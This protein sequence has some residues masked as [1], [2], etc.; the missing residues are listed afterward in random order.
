MRVIK[1]IKCLWIADLAQVLLL[2]LMLLLLVPVLV[3]L[4]MMVLMV[5]KHSPLRIARPAQILRRV[6]AERQNRRQNIKWSVVVLPPQRGRMTSSRQSRRFAQNPAASS[7]PSSAGGGTIQ[8]TCLEVI[9]LHVRMVRL[10]LHSKSELL[11]LHEGRHTRAALCVLG[12][13]PPPA[14]GALLLM[15]RSIKTAVGTLMLRH[16]KSGNAAVKSSSFSRPPYT[17][18]TRFCSKGRGVSVSTRSRHPAN[19]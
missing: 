6:S 17:R 16:A 3:L 10:P 9:R 19:S 12:V 8:S 18:R 4:V 1:I 13:Q 7:C 14:A 11:L 5:K 2:L 15:L